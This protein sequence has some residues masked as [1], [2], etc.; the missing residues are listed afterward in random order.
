MIEKEKGHQ[1]GENT[2][3]NES[4]VKRSSDRKEEGEEIALPMA[5]KP[6]TLKR[7]TTILKTTVRKQNVKAPHFTLKISANIVRLLMCKAH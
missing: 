6:K 4:H 1:N 2:S 5:V 3:E 7:A